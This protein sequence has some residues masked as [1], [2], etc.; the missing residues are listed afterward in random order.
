MRTGKKL[1]CFLLVLSLSAFAATGA[2]ARALAGEEEP[3]KT[4]EG[5]SVFENAPA[6]GEESLPGSGASLRKTEE[7]EDGF[8]SLESSFKGTAVFQNSFSDQLNARQ[9]AFYQELDGLTLDRIL[10]A[11]ETDGYHTIFAPVESV[12]GLKLSGSFDSKRNFTPTGASLTQ[13]QSLYTDLLAAV[14]AYRYDHPEAIWSASMQYGYR[15]DLAGPFTVTVTGVTF[16][17]RLLYGE[18]E[19]AI[20]DEMMESARSLAA[21]ASGGDYYTRVR[22]LHD[23]LASRCTYLTEEGDER[24]GQLSHTPYSALVAGDEYEPVCDGYSK[25]FK[26]LCDQLEIPCVLSVSKE[27][28]WNNVK[29]DDGAWYHVD[30]TWDDRGETPVDAYFL[31]GDRS[32]IG[33][34][35]FSGEADHIERNPYQRPSGHQ[36]VVFSYPVKSR[37][38]YVYLGHD[39]APLSFPD[40]LRSAWYYEAVEE[41]HSLGIFEGDEHGYFNPGSA[42]TRAQFVQALANALH[43]SLNEEDE[44][45][46]TDVASGKW[47][48]PAVAWAQRE[49]I[50]EGHGGR[51]RPNDPISREEMCVVFARVMDLSGAS[52]DFRFPDHSG[53]ASWAREAVYACYGAEL[54][55]GD[56]RG[57]FN[58]KKNTARREAAVVFTR[59]ARSL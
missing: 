39:Y 21:Q 20:Y 23:L 16:G 47:Y 59:W 31:L 52:S 35:E 44:S 26:L 12:Q 2:P 30:V 4:G 57:R 55:Q 40:V 53:I 29:M 6:Q 10:S 58:P 15:W 42:L 45:A 3:G 48:T 36:N 28:M 54:I 8:I 43:A 51:F 49:G 32:K 19:K 1:I 38:A 5:F 22:S 50:M 17:F 33:E 27:H 18:E 9:K 11:V 41:V 56:E 37:E 7:G 14:V 24:T 46:F 13:V 34:T 25:A